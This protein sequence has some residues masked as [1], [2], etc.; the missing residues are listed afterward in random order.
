MTGQ[1]VPA[2]SAARALPGRNVV[3]LVAVAVFSVLMLVIALPGYLDRRWVGGSARPR[4][5]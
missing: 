5:W 1:P 2:A 3:F 4:C